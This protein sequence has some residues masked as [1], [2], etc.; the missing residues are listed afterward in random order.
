[1]ILKRNSNVAI[2]ADSGL[3]ISTNKSLSREIKASPTGSPIAWNLWR[4]AYLY[5]IFTGKALYS[6]S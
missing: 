5:E 4:L 3:S 2:R 1:M 6:K